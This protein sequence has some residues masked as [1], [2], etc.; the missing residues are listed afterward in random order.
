MNL[1]NKIKLSIA[2]V[3]G[4]VAGAEVADASTLAIGLDDLNVNP[5][6]YEV[7]VFDGGAGDLNPLA[8]AITFLGPLGQWNLN[9][10]TGISGGNYID[11][12]SINTSV[13]DNAALRVSLWESFDSAFQCRD[14][15]IGGTTTGTVQATFSEIVRGQ[16]VSTAKSDLFSGGAFAQNDIKLPIFGPGLYQVEMSVDIF[17]PKAGVTSFDANCDYSPVPIPNA[18][19]LFGSAALGML[20]IGRRNLT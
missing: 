9:V 8:G 12:N 7:L 3:A 6:G 15:K 19:W 5:G 13:G 2:L 20:G 16:T 14:C 10:S 11:L 4:L 18:V 1:F 17:H